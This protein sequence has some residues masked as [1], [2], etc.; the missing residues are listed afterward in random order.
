MEGLSQKA[1]NYFILAKIAGQLGMNSEA[2]AN[3]FKAL[4]A[5]NDQILDSIGLKAKDHSERFSMLKQNFPYFYELT[6]RLFSVYRRTYTGEIKEEEVILL[7]KNIEE[8]FRNAKIPLPSDGEIK[9]R[10]KKIS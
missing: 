4:S 8:A 5:V 2:A 1:R 9:E 6:D 10:I 7:R 3:Y